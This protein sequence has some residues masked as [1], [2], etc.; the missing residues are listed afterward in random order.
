MKKIVLLSAL[1]LLSLVGF[2]QY[3]T[4]SYHGG[5]PRGGGPRGVSPSNAGPPAP[6]MSDHVV[7]TNHHGGHNGHHGPRG[8]PRGQGPRGYGVNSGASC[9]SGAVYT[10]GP[11]YGSG[12]GVGY[13]G[14]VA[15]TPVLPMCGMCHGHH[16]VM[17]IC[18]MEFRSIKRAVRA[19]CF[20]SDKIVVARQAVRRKLLSSDQVLRLLRV[21]TFESTKL[22]FAKFAYHHTSDPFNYY[23]VNDG[24]T[25][26]SSVRELDAYI[27]HC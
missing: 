21:F 15:V 8:G 25:F 23:I 3:A 2:S 17:N 20:E 14:G 6:A 18:E 4:N 24:F 7:V 12:N 27:R 10:S 16:A 26:R 9:G 13:S 5:G 19:Q 1:M 22:E 11:V